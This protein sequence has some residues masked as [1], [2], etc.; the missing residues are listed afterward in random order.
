MSK[1]LPAEHAHAENL[2]VVKF[3]PQSAPRLVEILESIVEAGGRRDWAPK[4]FSAFAAERP[5]WAIGT[6]GYPWIEIDFPEDYRRAAREV[7]PAIDA[8]DES[9]RLEPAAEYGRGL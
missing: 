2:G 6:R 8:L 9:R 1:T 3:G 7:L 5:L 4:S